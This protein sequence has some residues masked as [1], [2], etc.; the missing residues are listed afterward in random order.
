MHLYAALMTWE[1]LDQT[2]EA[3]ADGVI[4]TMVPY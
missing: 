1:D 2:L 3:G 4:F